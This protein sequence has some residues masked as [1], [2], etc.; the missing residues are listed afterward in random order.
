MQNK[1]ITIISALSVFI[2]VIIIYIRALPPTVWFIDSGELASVAITLGIAHPTGYPLFTLIS[3]LFSWLP[4]GSEIY[5]NNLLS[6]VF[7][8]LGAFM[9][10]FLMNYL[11]G[12]YSP[13]SQKNEDKTGKKTGQ[14]KTSAKPF[15]L[16]DQVRISLVIFT[17]L[18]LAFSKTYWFVVKLGKVYP[19]HVFFIITMMLFFLNGIFRT[20]QS[21]REDEPGNSNIVNKYFLIFAYILGLSFSNHMTTILIT[22]AWLTLFFVSGYKDLARTLKVL[23]TMV[24]FFIASISVYLYLPIRAAE[25][26]TFIWGNPVTFEKFIWHISGKQFQVLD[27]QRAGFAGN[28]PCLTCLL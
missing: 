4:L 27:I 21:N 14:Q 26:P 12:F 20:R 6:G 9:M 22:P 19:I 10:F 24:I 7:C 13:L 17:C 8:A 23:G 18:V 11:L 2:F 3:H 25:H 15:K 5:R 1:K 16:P 28:I